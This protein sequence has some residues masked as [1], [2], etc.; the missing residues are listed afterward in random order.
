MKEESFSFT[1][2]YTGSE[3]VVDAAY[4]RKFGR[5][6]VRELFEAGLYKP[7][8][9]RA[10]CGDNPEDRDYLLREFNKMSGEIRYKSIDQLKRLFGVFDRPRGIKKI[11]NI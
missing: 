3:A 4:R 1:V 2:G 5:Q 7:A 6:S 10:L 9:S 8:L 11:K